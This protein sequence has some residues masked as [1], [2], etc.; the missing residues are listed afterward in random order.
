LCTK[1]L[2]NSGYDIAVPSAVIAQ[3]QLY[4]SQYHTKRKVPLQ[5]YRSEYRHE[6]K[7]AVVEDATQSILN[8]ENMRG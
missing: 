6:D 3:Q 5:A 1:L 4:V 2:S 7:F 8:P